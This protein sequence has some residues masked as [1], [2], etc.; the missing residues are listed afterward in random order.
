[1]KIT[2]EFS[3]VEDVLNFANTFGVKAIMPNQV[4]EV[5]AAPVITENKK[6]EKKG[7]PEKETVQ[8]EKNTVIEQQQKE[9]EEPKITKELVRAVFAKLIKAGKAKEAKELTAKYGA[10]KI[11]EIKEEDYAAIYKEAEELL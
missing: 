9:D 1:M 6:V 11:P 4:E 8:E 3:S 7:E 5:K 10:S 2:A